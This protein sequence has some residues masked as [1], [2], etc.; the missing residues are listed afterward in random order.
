VSNIGWY[1]FELLV[2]TLLKA[3]I[4][5][6]VTS[7]GGSKD[8]GRDATFNGPASFPSEG[9]QWTGHWIFQVKFIDVEEQGVDAARSSLKSTFR[10][11]LAQVLDRH[12]DVDNYV[13]MTDVPMSSDTRA[14]LQDICTQANYG[15][16]FAAVDGKE[17]CQF[18]DI[19]PEIRRSFPQL[20]GL[21][22]LDLIVNHDLYA[23]SRAYLEAWQPRLATYVHTEA[24]ARA[25]ALLKKRHFIVLDG[26]PEAGKTTIAA[27]LALIHATEGFEI[28]DTRLSNDL[29]KPPD[30][31][32]ASSSGRE[33]ARLF[34]ADDA[35]GSISL[36]PRLADGW[37]RDL[38]GILRKLNSKRLLIWTARRYI[39]EEALAKSRLK[40]A[41]QDFPK[42][43]DVLVEVG[44]LTVMQKAEMLYNHAKAANLRPEYRE[45]V[46]VNAQRIIHHPNFTPLR[47]EQLMTVVLASKEDSTEKRVATW[48]DVSQFLANPGERWIQAYRALSSSEQQLLSAMLDFDGPVPLRELRVRYE[49]RVSMRVGGHLTFDDALNWVDHSF[50]VLR[51]SYS[52]ERQ[53]SFQHPSLRDLLLLEMRGDADARIRYF[54]IA[55]PFALAS[56][57]GGIATTE[58][59][60]GEPQHAVVP[61]TDEE[62]DVFLKRLE[63]VSQEVLKLRDWELLLSAAERL[64]PSKPPTSSNGQLQA[65]WRNIGIPSPVELIDPVDLDLNAFASQSKG[66]IIRAI[67]EGFALRRTFD[68]N[69]RY[70]ESDW[71]RLLTKFYRL[72]AYLAPPVYP[73]FTGELCQIV[74]DSM[75]AVRLVNEISTSEPIV[76]KQTVSKTRRNE[77]RDTIESDASELAHTG[78]QF[79]NSDDPDEFDQWESNVDELIDTAQGFLKWTG[80]DE[81]GSLAEITK[82]RESAERPREHEPEDGHYEQRQVSGP[83]WTIERMFED[84]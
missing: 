18:L 79:D 43:H 75:D 38:P 57:M 2:Q 14:A 10:K 9:V 22:D 40:D 83:Y 12:E 65:I 73:T 24:H 21:V 72:T 45:L 48:E 69:Q 53:A 84:L 5:P 28:I 70:S 49:A 60:E 25:V 82:V 74:S 8:G 6:G 31:L 81:I 68:N 32:L 36:E 23:R 44:N 30:D 52:G 34:V 76:V 56:I 16:N 41:I 7:F 33:T 39:L 35:I 13:L 71:F 67:L 80:F 46:R 27:A 42:P 51:D 64:I 3:V 50:L 58:E 55:T 29:F 77:W 37:S 19:Y 61:V 54:S 62:F 11:E 1:N 78:R 15:R 20:L 63:D 47:I 59:V 26:P 66:R 17:V 4:G